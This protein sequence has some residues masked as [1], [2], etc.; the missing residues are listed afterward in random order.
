MYLHG[1]LWGSG[2]TSALI[3]YRRILSHCGSNIP[4]AGT[5]RNISS[6][7]S[8][9]L[10]ASSTFRPKHTELINC[11]GKPEEF[12]RMTICVSSAF[13]VGERPELRNRSTIPARGK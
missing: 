4:L 12:T 9:S 8:S 7:A 2:L 6:L 13:F 11:L 1:F 3:T 5:K 10:N